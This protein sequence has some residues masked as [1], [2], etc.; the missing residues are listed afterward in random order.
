MNPG[1]YTAT[2]LMSGSSLDGVDLATCSFQCEGSTWSYRI[3][4]AETLPYP[5][6]LKEAL[7]RAMSWDE[8]KTDKLD[9]DLGTFYGEMVRKFHERHRVWPDLVASH[10]HTLF[11]EPEKGITRQLGNGRTLAKEA[12]ITVVCD[13]RSEDVLQGGQGAP[14]VP[15]GDE[16]LFPEYDACLNLGGFANLSYRGPAGQRLAYDIGPA[17]LALDAIAG[18]AGLTYDKNGTLAQ[19]GQ[20]D[21]ELLAKMDGLDYYRKHPPKSLG[22]EWFIGRF[23]PLI[24]NREQGIPNLMATACEHI[25]AQV[26]KAVVQPGAESILATGG[27]ALNRYL[28]GRLQVHTGH[29]IRVPQKTLVNYK[30]ALV[31]A[32]LG[33]LRTLGEVNCLAS[34]T[35]GKRN[36]STGKIFT[37]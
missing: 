30:E 31:F 22:R 11:H 2:G 4:A 25:A 8:T 26:G 28:V 15:V 5:A 20:V 1:S 29:R 32:L 14:L 13:F 7:V 21:Q 23:L 36:I 6:R 3:L 9:R 37:N 34:V 17:N 19:Q 12:G 18:M 16:L 24:S 35:G 33:I 10:G 27:G